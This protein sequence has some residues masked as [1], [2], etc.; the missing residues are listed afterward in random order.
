V[1]TCL[2]FETVQKIDAIATAENKSRSKVISE[3]IQNA[4][5]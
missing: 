2:P 5:S 4:F 3:I 1:G